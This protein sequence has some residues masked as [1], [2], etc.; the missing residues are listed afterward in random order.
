M[1]EACIWQYILLGEAKR[2][3]GGVSHDVDIIVG[4]ELR[5][6]DTW[7]QRGNKEVKNLGKSDY[8]IS[9]LSLI[10]IFP[11]MDRIVSVF[12][13]NTDPI[14][15]IYRKLRIRESPYFGIFYAVREQELDAN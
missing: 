13:R 12:S 8:V 15:S 11:F 3:G 9:G 10:L 5:N 7:L 2:G 14:L 4:G 1:N 6:D